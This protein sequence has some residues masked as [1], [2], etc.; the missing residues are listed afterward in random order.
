MGVKWWAASSSSK[1]KKFLSEL[2]P[3]VEAM[4]EP[5]MVAMMNIIFVL[6]GIMALCLGFM[7]LSLWEAEVD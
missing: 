5:A 4:V 1:V 6:A 3:M 2:G 7:V